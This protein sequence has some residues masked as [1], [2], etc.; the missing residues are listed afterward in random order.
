MRTF[1]VFSWWVAFQNKSSTLRIR[2]RTNHCPE[3]QKKGNMFRPGT[4]EAMIMVTLLMNVLS[5]ELM[6]K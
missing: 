3:I 5:F 4:D 6:N 2:V 1:I